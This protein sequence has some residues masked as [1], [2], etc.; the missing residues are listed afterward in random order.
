LL[1]RKAEYEDL[2]II[3]EIFKN[4][5]KIMNDNNINQWDDLYPTTTDLEQDVLNGQMYVGI[6]DGEIA[7]ALVINNECEEEYKYGNWRYDN[8][9]FAVV[10]R[11]CVN[12][13]YQNKKIGKDTMIKIE[14]ILKTEGIQSI[15]L[16]TYSLNPYALKMYQT[17]GYQK[18][19]DVK[20]RKGLFYLLEKKL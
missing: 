12:P 1:I 15:R 9:K 14:E 18:V 17:L 4:A 6:K 16:D 2:N 19:G 8:D 3:L 7:S 11:L 5:I 13:S 10:H 20:W